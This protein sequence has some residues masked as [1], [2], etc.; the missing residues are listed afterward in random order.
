MGVKVEVD[1]RVSVNGRVA[2]WVG[3]KIG[4]TVA[5]GDGVNDGNE[6]DVQVGVIVGAAGR[7]RLNP[8]QPMRKKAS[9]AIPITVFRKYLQWMI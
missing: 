5:N 7:M 3:K 1:V 6:L 4:V 2:V 9:A 8:P